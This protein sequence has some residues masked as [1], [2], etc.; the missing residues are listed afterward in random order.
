ME[1]ERVRA[2]LFVVY[3]W[4]KGNVVAVSVVVVIFV[5][6]AVILN[7]V[8]VIVMLPPVSHWAPDIEGTKPESGVYFLFCARCQLSVI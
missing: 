8:V 4:L 3:W 2:F 1:K 6:A 5:V 7:V